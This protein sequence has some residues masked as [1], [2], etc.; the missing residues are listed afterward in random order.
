MGKLVSKATY[1][2]SGFRN[3]IGGTEA[4][5]GWIRR[6]DLTKPIRADGSKKRFAKAF[7]LLHDLTRNPLWLFRVPTWP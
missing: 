2:R 4:V 5:A 1:R 7:V 3:S 6:L